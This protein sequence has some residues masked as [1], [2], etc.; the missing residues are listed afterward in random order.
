MSAQD[1]HGGFGDADEP[2]W[3]PLLTV[4]G[5]ELVG[6]FMWMFPIDLDD[7]TRIEAY[8][9]RMS[10]R[11]LYLDEEARPWGYSEPEHYRRMPT[12]AAALADVLA[13]W[14]TSPLIEPKETAACWA[15]I[16]AAR[17]AA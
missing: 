13:S 4:V 7:G 11:Y 3:E 8:K 6:D 5:E 15:A 17:A 10:R 14:L 2:N 12:L 1:L 16:D 9:H